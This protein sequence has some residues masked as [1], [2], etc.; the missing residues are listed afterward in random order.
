MARYDRLNGRSSH[1]GLAV[2]HKTREALEACEWL[3]FQEAGMA[4]FIMVGHIAV[5]AITGDMTPATLSGKVVTEILKGDLGFSGLVITDA[6]NMGAITQ[7]CPAGEAAVR[8]LE[9][10]C[11]IVLMPENLPEAFEAVMAAL[12]SGRLTREWL[13]ETVRE[14]LEFKELHGIL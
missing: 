13:D 8:A 2:N 6:M 1:S 12:D 3:P 4:D 5:P 7:T 14:I 11:H 10:G 9:A